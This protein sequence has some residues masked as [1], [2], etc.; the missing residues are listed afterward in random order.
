LAAANEVD[1]RQLFLE[2]AE[3]AKHQNKGQQIGSPGVQ[4]FRR[5]AIPEAGRK[6]PE[7]QTACRTCVLLDL[8]SGKC[9]STVSVKNTKRRSKSSKAK[10][11][12]TETKATARS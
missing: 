11:F 3:Q 5:T 8:T 6:C 2:L 10:S 4:A 9:E 12:Q 1:R 7:K